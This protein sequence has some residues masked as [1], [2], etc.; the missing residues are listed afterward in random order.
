VTAQHVYVMTLTLPDGGGYTSVHATYAGAEA[1]LLRQVQRF[2]VMDEYLL[3]QGGQ[4]HYAMRAGAPASTVAAAD[5]EGLSYG[6]SYLE[7]EP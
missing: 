5:A 6:I 3:A 4:Q 2:A 7:V 1:S